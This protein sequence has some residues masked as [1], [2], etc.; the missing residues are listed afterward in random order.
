V[1]FL[2]DTNVVAE[3]RK[4]SRANPRVRSWFTALDPQA[5]VLSVVTVGD[6]RKGIETLRR[7]DRSAAQSLERWLRR[8]L[9]DYRDR[10]LDVD[11]S[12]ADMWGRINA[13]DPLP[14]IDGLL[15]ATARVHGLTLATRNVKNVG[16]SGADIVNPFES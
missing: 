9:R 11:V 13:P 12:V 5:I 6:I 4:G 3:L 16:R 10:I 14:V 8:L 1:R 15:A 2:L 7:R